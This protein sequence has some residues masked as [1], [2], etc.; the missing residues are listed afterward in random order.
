MRHCKL[1]KKK[2]GGDVRIFT[3]I[4]QIVETRKST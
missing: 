4:R 1:V 3:R 2:I